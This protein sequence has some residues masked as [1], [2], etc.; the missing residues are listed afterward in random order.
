MTYA[1]IATLS[2]DAAL[3][4]RVIAC[5][6]DEGKSDFPEDWVGQRRWLFATTPGWAD[7]W[8]S[9]VANG[10]ENP[11]ADETVITDAAILARV[12]PLDLPP[13]PE[14]LSATPPIDIEDVPSS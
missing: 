6:A 14:E 9:A 7:A 1:T 10:V 12:Q 8:E 13:E 11:G 3:R 2:E 5:A 4:R